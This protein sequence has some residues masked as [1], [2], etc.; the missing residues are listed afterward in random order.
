M[1]H[2][3]LDLAFGNSPAAARILARGPLGV[4][5]ARAVE[6]GRELK[7]EELEGRWCAIGNCRAIADL[8]SDRQLLP[9]K[10]HLPTLRRLCAKA[11][12]NV[13]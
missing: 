9:S 13:P 12:G 2:V 6:S 8:R 11:Q 7:L 10:C 3:T 4:R 5:S 1:P